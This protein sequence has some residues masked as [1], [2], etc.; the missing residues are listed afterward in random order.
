MSVGLILALAVL[1]IGL[2]ALAQERTLA[3]VG[4]VVAGIALLVA[5]L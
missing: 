5:A 1:L 3:A 2:V 4:V